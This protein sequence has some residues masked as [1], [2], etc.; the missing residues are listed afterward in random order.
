MFIEHK[1]SYQSQSSTTSK[2]SSD[3]TFTTDS[4]S[5]DNDIKL[6]NDD[7]KST[8]TSC[9]PCCKLNSSSQFRIQNKNFCSS[10]CKRIK[11]S[12]YTRVSYY[13]NNLSFFATIIAYFLIQ[14]ALSIIQYHLYASSNMAVRFARIGG[15][16]LDFN[17]GVII[18]LVLRRL[19]TWLR[20]SV[21]GRNYLPVD[22]FI[23]FHKFVGIFILLLSI[24]HTVAHCINL[25]K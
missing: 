9:L 21:I 16:L 18:L 24:M 10:F 7:E 5:F 22:D 12:K 8:S 15:I 11:K 14:I 23:K 2:Q 13:R 20:N 19:T 17:S 3:T 1:L 25:C 6:E 4:K